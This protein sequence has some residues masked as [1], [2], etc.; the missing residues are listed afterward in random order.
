M[1]KQTAFGILLL[2]IALTLVWAD[3]RVWAVAFLVVWLVVY[4]LRE[5]R[6]LALRD[7]PLDELNARYAIDLRLDPPSGARS[8]PPVHYRS[9][10][11]TL[12]D[13][14]TAAGPDNAAQA[15]AVRYPMVHYCDSESDRPVL[16]A[17]HGI[18]DSAHGWQGWM[19]EIGHHYRIVAPDLPGFGLTG[20]L[21]AGDYAVSMWVHFLDDFVAALRIEHFHLAGSSLGGGVAWNYAIRHPDKVQRLVLVDPV[22][23]PQEVPDAVRIVARPGIAAIVPLFTPRWIFSGYVKQVYGDPARVT[24]PVVDR[25]FEI[26][27]RPGSRPAMIRVFQL[28]VQQSQDETLP[29]GIANLHRLG[30]PTLLLW[31]EKD[32]WIPV[33]HV[34]RWQQDVPSIQAIVYSGAGHIPHEEMPEQTAQDVHRFLSCE[35]QE[36]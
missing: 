6:P 30:I 33:Q 20:P 9:R 5:V 8:H 18:M 14:A 29:N 23:Y 17:L 16:V 22:G 28:L 25:F 2:I 1:R 19:R 4:L 13:P 27:L 21:L 36:T 34:A 11:I 15:G 32:R 26:A 3:R 35:R 31:G 12:G 24:R 7:I 10:Y